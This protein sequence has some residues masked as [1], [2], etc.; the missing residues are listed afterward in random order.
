VNLV[1]RSLEARGLIRTS[2]G[3]FEILDHDQLQHLAEG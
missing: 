1:L 2:G 3:A